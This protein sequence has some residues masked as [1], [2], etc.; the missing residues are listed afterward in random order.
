MSP[1]LTL[2]ERTQIVKEGRKST[3]PGLRGPFQKNSNRLPFPRSIPLNFNQRSIARL[4]EVAMKPN[5]VG[6]KDKMLSKSTQFIGLVSQSPLR[7]DLTDFD[8]YA[9][10]PRNNMISC[11]S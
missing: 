4:I 9:V 1:S 8:S 3:I 2:G 11:I 6:S 5:A 7:L 10:L